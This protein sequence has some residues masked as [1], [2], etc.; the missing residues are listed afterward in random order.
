MKEVDINTSQYQNRLV[1]INVGAT[2]GIEPRTMSVDT[3]ALIFIANYG[4]YPTHLRLDN[5]LTQRE[6]YG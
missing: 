3:S 2:D 5:G 1:D 4:P 6:L